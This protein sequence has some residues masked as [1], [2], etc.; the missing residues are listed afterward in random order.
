MRSELHS[1]I[2]ILFRASLDRRTVHSKYGGYLIW[3]LVRGERITV[4]SIIASVLAIPASITS[5]L[6]GRRSKRPHAERRHLLWA[7][8]GLDDEDQSSVR[9]MQRAVFDGE[10]LDFE[11]PDPLPSPIRTK[12]LPSYGIAQPRSPTSRSFGGSSPSIFVRAQN[13]IRPMRGY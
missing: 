9:P 13:W 11:D 1:V 7:A 4:D 3:L 6:R 5:C 8:D 2:L 10:E 12:A